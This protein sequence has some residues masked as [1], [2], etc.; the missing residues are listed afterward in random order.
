MFHLPKKE[1]RV[2]R[3]LCRPEDNGVIA[4]PL[5][6]KS[7]LPDW[8]RKLPAVDQTHLSTTN[9]GLTVKRCMPFLDAM[10]TGWI[11]P[12]AATVRLEI[13]DGGRSVEAGWEFDRVM[14]SNHGAHQVAGNPRE[15]SPPC[16]FHNYWSIR[17]PPGWSCLFLPPLNRAGQPF[18]CVAG[19][20]DTDT[21]AAHIH[22]PFF[23]TAPDGL[24]AI[25]KGTPL[26]QVIPFRRAD[27]AVTADIRAETRNEA[28]ERETIH[29]NTIAGAGWYRKTARAAR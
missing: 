4:A 15:P 28:M 21:Y 3:F 24:Y 8:F 2:I 18:E 5:P 23:A 10:T 26:V 1:P 9:N 14:V 17:T 20:V 13:K 7:V 16:K 11:L 6:A 12:L 27:A 25:E 19:V 29:R 22:F